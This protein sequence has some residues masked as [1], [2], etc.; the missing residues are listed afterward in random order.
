MFSAG[1]YIKGYL[2]R[3]PTKMLYGQVNALEDGGV[4]RKNPNKNA[5]EAAK[6]ISISRGI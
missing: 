2:E 1:K 3:I 4:F 5:V 6:A